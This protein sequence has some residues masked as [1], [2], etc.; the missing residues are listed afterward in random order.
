MK[1]Y[2]FILILAVIGFVPRLVVAHPTSSQGTLSLMGEHS[3]DM[4][5]Y[6]VIYSL[7]Y[8]L[9]LGAR[10]HQQRYLLGKTDVALGTMGFLL[11]RSNGEEHQGNVYL[12]G[13]AGN[14]WFK[15][16]DNNT[17]NDDFAYSTG[18]QADYETR[19][20]YTLAKYENIKT[21]NDII[22]EYYELRAGFAPFVAGYYDLNAWFI[23]Q[24]TMD[25]AESESID[26]APVIRLFYKNV[27]TEFGSTIDGNF[28]FNFMV[29]Y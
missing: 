3:E 19:K 4:S 28:I 15:D 24:A 1:I 13:G 16:L 18:I 27:L 8:W 23:L 29:H 7:K 26:L 22:S 11:Y 20:I 9:G 2:L 21:K 17:L 14:A 25:R 6:D 5:H 12:V 10:M